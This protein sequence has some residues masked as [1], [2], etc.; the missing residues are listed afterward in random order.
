MRYNEGITGEVANTYQLHKRANI[1]SRVNVP[2]E[3]MKLRFSTSISVREYQSC[4]LANSTLIAG[5]IPYV[6]KIRVRFFSQ[7]IISAAND[8]MPYKLNTIK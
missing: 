4:S 1:E 2:D 3:G 8:D 6:L 7:K 5:E